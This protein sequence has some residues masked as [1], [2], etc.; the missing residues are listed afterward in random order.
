MQLESYEERI[1]HL[2]EEG[3]KDG[4]TLRSESEEDFLLI[5]NAVPE[6]GRAGLVLMEDGD[7]RATWRKEGILRVVI[8]AEF[9]EFGVRYSAQV[10]ESIKVAACPTEAFV[11]DLR[12]YFKIR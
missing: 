4:I 3:A 12:C 10:E 5:A 6:A 11:S 1:S 8:S 2:R 9:R 7:L